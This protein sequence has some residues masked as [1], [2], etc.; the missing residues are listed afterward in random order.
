MEIFW[1]PG[2]PPPLADHVIYG[3]PLTLFLSVY[4]SD[5]NKRV[6]PNKRGDGKISTHP[7]IENFLNRFYYAFFNSV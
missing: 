2:P 1:P 5:P 4:S 7:G 6:A 3:C